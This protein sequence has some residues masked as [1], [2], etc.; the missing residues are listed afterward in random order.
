MVLSVLYDMLYVVLPLLLNK[1]RK[2]W[3]Y[4]HSFASIS[5]KKA[6]SVHML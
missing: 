4:V 5:K 2:L 1:D 3:F 6:P